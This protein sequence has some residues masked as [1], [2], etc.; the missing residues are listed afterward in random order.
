[1]TEALEITTFKLTGC[2]C[3]EFISANRELDT[4]L[5]RQPGFRSRR[6]AEQDDGSIVDMLI[7]DTV[8]NGTASMH[9]LMDEMRDS[10]VHGMIEQR[11]V[12]WNIMP[13]QH[14]IKR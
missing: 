5:K 12:S 9:R 10:P 6:M 1:M 14:Q 7:W 4:W 8:A 11:S 2:T 13:V 3:E